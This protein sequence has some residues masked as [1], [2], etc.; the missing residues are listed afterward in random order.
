MQGLLGCRFG[1]LGE[2]ACIIG[3]P[4]PQSATPGANDVNYPLIGPL[5]VIESSAFIA[6]PL[7][8]LTLA[9]FGA[10]VIRVDLIGGGID[11][12]RLPLAP[13]GRSLYW[14]GLNK[15]KRSVAIDLRKPQGRELLRS[16]VA[17]PGPDGGV[18][19]TNIGTPWLSHT[20]LAALRADV[21]SCTIS[22]NPDGST[23][24]DYTVNAATGYPTVTGN[25]SLAAP[26]NHVL[27]AWDVACAYQAACAVLA[28]VLHRR[29]TGAGAELRLALSDVAFA[30]LSNLGVLAE[31]ELLDQDR[32]NLGNHIYGAFG[33]DFGTRDGHR[34]MV[35]GISAGQ[36]SALCAACGLDA[37]M[38]AMD[39]P[40]RF[41]ARE[42]IA[43]VVQDWCAARDLAQ[44]EGVFAQYKV[45]WGRYRSV[46]DL[47]ANDPRVGLGNP[48]FGQIDTAGVGTHRAAGTPVRVAG[49]ERADTVPAPWLGQHTEEVLS[50][51]LGLDSPAIGR[52]MDARVVAGPQ[53]DPHRPVAK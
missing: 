34:V 23:A 53:Q 11:Y 18:L 38:A 10:D 9:Q 39:E 32:P 44:V 15:A 52:L 36:W 22:G 14:T 30:T 42:A 48:I 47:F 3:R 37:S 33:R 17:A 20:A 24:V 2:L 5:R 4:M 25:G 35:A 12:G 27:P 16:L 46:R 6:A 41:A 13:G 28:A 50:S 43:E 8:G 7:A 19:L 1:T 21:I 29:Q 40:S 51:V 49:M 26:V 31:A 45:C